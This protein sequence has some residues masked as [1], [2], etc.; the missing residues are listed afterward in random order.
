M[1][2]FQFS[3]K[4]PLEALVSGVS[5]GR[6][7]KEARDD[8]KKKSAV[9]SLLSGV[10]YDEATGAATPTPGGAFEIGRK[11]D[12]LAL[13]TGE[14]GL[15]K[16]QAE[17]EKLNREL[18][19]IG[20]GSQK[21]NALGADAKKQ[22]SMIIDALRP[23]TDYDTSFNKGV[24]RSYINPDTPLIGGLIGSTSIDRA[25]TNLSD[26]IGRLRSGGAINK[27]EEARFVKMLPTPADSEPQARAKLKDLRAE[28]ENKLR[29]YN[30]T[31]Q[32]LAGAGY[33]LNQ[34]GY[35]NGGGGGGNFTPDVLDYAK[36]YNITPEEAQQIKVSRGG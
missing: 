20:S 34:L 6:K 15:K 7:E 18:K 10:S 31:P 36:R 14:A 29:V 11:K 19:S 28:F 30:L 21:L 32:E 16:T 8:R 35:G 12:D 27:D 13:R 1:A 23:L 9:E 5:E 17:T 25:T 4:S 22:A 24:R 26:T 3:R 2:E 33:D